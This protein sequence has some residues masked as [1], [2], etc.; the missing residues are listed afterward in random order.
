M[1]CPS[2]SLLVGWNLIPIEK[3]S[4]VLSSR[5]SDSSADRILP[6][7]IFCLIHCPADVTVVSDLLFIQRFRMKKSINGEVAYCLTN[8]EA[9]ICFLETVDLAS[10]KLDDNIGSTTLDMRMDTIDKNENSRVI[11]SALAA[12]SSSSTE[13]AS[14]SI[15]APSRTQSRGRQPTYEPTIPDNP[16]DRSESSTFVPADDPLSNL[17]SKLLSAKTDYSLRVTGESWEPEVEKAPSSQLTRSPDSTRQLPSKTLLQPSPPPTG[18]GTEAVRNRA[19]SY[20]TKNPVVDVA[21]SVVMGAD[22]GLKTIGDALGGSYKF[23]FGRMD[24]K[25]QEMPKTLEDAR[26]LVEQPAAP[27]L[28]ESTERKNDLWDSNS[29]LPSPPPLPLPV[30]LGDREKERMLQPAAAFAA[31]GTGLSRVVGMGSEVVMRGFTRSSSSLSLDK[32]KEKDIAGATTA[33]V[34]TLGVTG[35][36]P[37]SSLPLAGD[38][39]TVSGSV[40]EISPPSWET[41][42]WID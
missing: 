14:A 41:D 19:L 8:L 27:S 10:L 25:R 40:F 15:P 34:T 17:S 26:R 33:A 9:A 31:V 21:E 28:L 1:V 12:G 4:D 20:L 37:Q 18:G 22:V 35:A 13:S 24:E 36:D 29:P 7:F 6:T 39:L 23:L 16:P 42:I 5:N 32:E 3:Y 11:A 2:T 38:L 30:R